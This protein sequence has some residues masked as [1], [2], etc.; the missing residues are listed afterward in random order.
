MQLD[1]ATPLEEEANPQNFPR[2][3]KIFESAL[4][5]HA[6]EEEVEDKNKS[7]FLS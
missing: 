3:E 1:N 7:F 5:L 6:G 2:L 4:K